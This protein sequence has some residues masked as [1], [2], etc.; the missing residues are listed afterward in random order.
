M[1]KFTQICFVMELYFKT[2]SATCNKIV[3]YIS[4]QIVKGLPFSQELWFLGT[5]TVCWTLWTLLSRGWW[6]TAP[7]SCPPAHWPA[8]LSVRSTPSYPLKQFPHFTFILYRVS[9]YWVLNI[10]Q[11]ALHTKWNKKGLSGAVT[12]SQLFTCDRIRVDMLILILV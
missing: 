12:D 5:W 3:V 6:S 11:C 2:T 10:H 9:F 7:Q 1:E 8:R 4:I